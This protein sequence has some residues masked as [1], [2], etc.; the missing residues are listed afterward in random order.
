MSELVRIERNAGVAVIRMERVDKHNAFNRALSDALG[1]AFDELEGDASIV[2]TIL[3]GAGT[4][5][6]AG[7]DMTEAIASIEGTG[8]SEGMYVTLERIGRYP[9]PLIGC[10]NGIAYGG[11]ALIATL[12][13]VRV[14]SD[15]AAFRFPGAAYGLVV[16]ASHLPRIIGPAYAKE[17][18]FTARVVKADEALRIGLVN[19]VVPHAHLE[20][21]TMEM[22]RQIAANSLDALIGTKETVDRATHADDGIDTEARWNLVLR[23][24]PEHHRRFRE[25]TERVA[26]RP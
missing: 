2:C 13:D 1:A 5:F 12:C 19:R 22:A 17:L 24:S 4:A 10:I 20:A 15:I 18:L 8:R 6:S 21:V 14:A 11:G 16:G 26:K 3:T 7:A 9:K 25:A 23:E